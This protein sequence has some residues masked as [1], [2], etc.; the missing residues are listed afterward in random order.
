MILPSK[1]LMRPLGLGF[2]LIRPVGD[3]PDGGRC[4]APAV[5]LQGPFQGFLLTVSVV[6]G[7]PA[8]IFLGAT[9]KSADLDVSPALL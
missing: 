8:E 6:S 4:G 9:L 2:L 7:H 3:R 5:G 1:G